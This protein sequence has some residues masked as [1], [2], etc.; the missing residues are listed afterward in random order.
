M[1]PPQPHP[2]PSTAPYGAPVTS[3]YGPAPPFPEAR[4]SG[5]PTAVPTPMPGYPHTPGYP[6]TSP[7]SPMMQPPYAPMSSI[8]QTQFQPASPFRCGPLLRYQNLDIQQGIWIG[9][10]LVVSRPEN[11]GQP[12]VLT[13]SDNKT[14]QNVTAEVI[15]GY[16]HSYF[17]RYSL[18]IPQEQVTKTITYSF[19]NGPAKW[20]FYIAGR[21]ETFRWM[22]F[23][24]NG[25]SSSTD[26][27][28]CE[29]NDHGGSQAGVIGGNC[30]SGIICHI[31]S[32][33]CCSSPFLRMRVLF[34]RHVCSLL[35]LLLNSM[36]RHEKRCSPL[37][38]W[39]SNFVFSTLPAKKSERW[40]IQCALMLL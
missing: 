3:P 10:I 15:E 32:L 25:F 34:L 12:P 11:Q 9:S 30:K 17:W 23:S 2:T 16:Q 27:S 21:P 19:N 33:F 26:A 38:S 6:P 22:F 18:R 13:W 1:Y 28:K 5:L 29:S 31:L 8:P 37:G 35:C 14:S 7:T 40:A 24:C 20:Y 4:P 39:W 36:V